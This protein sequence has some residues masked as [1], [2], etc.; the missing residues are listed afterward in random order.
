[1]KIFD[2]L[3]LVYFVMPMIFVVENKIP[4]LLSII[5]GRRK[6]KLK[7]SNTNLEF[8]DYE[9]G[10]VLC[11]LLLLTFSINYKIS[12][13]QLKVSLDSKNFFEFDLNNL[14]YE[15]KNLI[16]TLGLGARHGGDF[17]IG[18]NKKLLREKSFKIYE[19]ENKK[20]IETFN[21]IKFYLDSIHPGNTIVETYIQKIHH[22]NNELDFNGKTVIDIGAECGDTALYYASL[23]AKVLAFEPMPEHFR[24]MM[25]NLSLNPDLS[26]NIIAIN[27]AI[28]E[29]GEL[30][31]YQNKDGKVGGTSFLVNEHGN[32]ANKTI[33]K[34]LSFSSL[35]NE[36]KL[37][38]VYLLK[39]DCKGCE[40][41]LDSDVLNRVKQ[42]KIE[43]EEKYNKMDIMSFLQK[44]E[45]SMFEN[46]VYRINPISNRISNKHSC[47]IFGKK[48]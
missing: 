48:L 1:M 29:D 30:T 45:S 44:L 38:D 3:G 34:G 26:K 24:D 12:N 37:E 22:V 11:L 39:M 36:Y 7:V 47:H 27:C 6:I 42:I 20:I 21:G 41:F 5:L 28:G 13:K 9:F 17:T 32:E 35:F 4:F 19:V 46:Q 2:K 18:K 33:V 25:K 43:Y 40:R 31:F 8:F 10:L 14:T 16:L 23:G 15:D